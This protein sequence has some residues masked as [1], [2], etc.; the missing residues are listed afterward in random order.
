MRVSVLIPTKDRPERLW[1]AIAAVLS[2]DWS[3][4]EVIVK[5]GGAHAAPLPHDARVR[6]VDRDG[7]EDSISSALNAAAAVATGDVLHVACDDD[8]MLPGTIRSAVAALDAG[9][10]W[11]YGMLMFVEELPGGRLRDWT[12]DYEPWPWQ[13]DEMLNLNCVHQPTVF[14]RAELHRDLGGFDETFRWAHDYE[15]WGRLGAHAEPV[16]RQHFDAMYRMWPGSTSVATPTVV[17]MEAQAIRARWATL[18]LGR[19]PTDP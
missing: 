7:T 19:R 3:D 17:E 11:T 13:P 4:L 10:E 8:E 2:Q 6:R 18:G 16:S 12:V 9:A 14:Y 15:W 5:D 1:R